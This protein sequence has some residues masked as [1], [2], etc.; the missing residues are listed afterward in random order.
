M[1]RS[2]NKQLKR[3]T[4]RIMAKSLLSI[5]CVSRAWPFLEQPQETLAR[6]IATCIDEIEGG[7][8]LLQGSDFT[9]AWQR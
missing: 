6:K 9:I 8:R 7:G 2:K 3:I 5:I 4:A 1:G